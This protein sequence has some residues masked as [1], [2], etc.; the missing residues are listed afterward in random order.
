M[1]EIKHVNFPFSQWNSVDVLENMANKFQNIS[2]GV[3]EKDPTGIKKAGNNLLVGI[4]N[5]LDANAVKGE[6]ETQTDNE[7]DETNDENSK[8]NVTK[9]CIFFLSPYSYLQHL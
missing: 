3:S 6:T 8:V 5:V 4:G 9:V 1:E 2:V 7:Q